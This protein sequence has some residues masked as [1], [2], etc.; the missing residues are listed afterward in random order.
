MKISNSADVDKGGVSAP[1]NAVNKRVQ[2][3]P[4]E[5]TVCGSDGSVTASSRDGVGS[6]RLAPA[7]MG[8]SFSAC[9]AQSRCLL[10]GEVSGCAV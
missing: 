3:P 5:L 10:R 2:V 7:T 8:M 1:L 9:P 4:A 6:N